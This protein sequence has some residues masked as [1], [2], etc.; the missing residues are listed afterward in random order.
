MHRPTVIDFRPA[1]IVLELSRKEKYGIGKPRN[2][3]QTLRNKATKLNKF[4]FQGLFIP[5]LLGVL[6]GSG[7]PKPTRHW[8]LGTK[9]LQAICQSST[10]LALGCQM[11]RLEGACQQCHHACAGNAASC[12]SHTKQLS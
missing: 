10:G 5:G 9:R 8:C 7:V 12:L 4:Y 6:R 11:V 1:E 2:P 3:A